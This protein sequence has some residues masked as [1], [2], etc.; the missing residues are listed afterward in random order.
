MSAR[1]RRIVIPGGSGQVG[2]ILARHFHEIGHDVTVISRHARPAEWNSI[3]WTGSDPGPWM[4]A[5]DGC[6]VVINL[7]GRSVNCR[8]NASNQSA[9]KTSRTVTTGLVGEAIRSAV[10]PP[11]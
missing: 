5:I 1:G 11:P 8:Y 9:I 6:D 4:K 3:S 10:H 2:T 7:A